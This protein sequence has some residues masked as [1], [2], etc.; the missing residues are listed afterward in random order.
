L[1]AEHPVCGFVQPVAM[2]VDGVWINKGYLVQKAA[3]QS[4]HLLLWH[5][6]VCRVPPGVATFGKPSYHHMLCF[7]KVTV[8]SPT[9][10][11]AQ[12][13]VDNGSVC[14]EAH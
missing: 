10:L 1:L 2:Q 5:K 4:G 6:L 9:T 11:P 14:N 12:S 7:S 8:K 3:E 13:L